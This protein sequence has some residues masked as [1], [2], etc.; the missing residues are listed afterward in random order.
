[1]RIMGKLLN[2]GLAVLPTV[3]HA[4]VS[5]TDDITELLKLQGSQTPLVMRAA[6]SAVTLQHEESDIPNKMQLHD[7]VG[8]QASAK[9]TA[10][11]LAT[12]ALR[13]QQPLPVASL[14]VGEALTYQFLAGNTVGD[15]VVTPQDQQAKT[16]ALTFLRFAQANGLDAAE[17]FL[18]KLN[19]G[20]R[21]SIAQPDGA[22]GTMTARAAVEAFQSNG[23]GFDLKYASKTLSVRGPVRVVA[24]VGNKASVTLTGIERGDSDKQRLSDEIS[25]DVDDPTTVATLSPKQVVSVTGTYN[26]QLSHGVGRIVLTLCRVEGH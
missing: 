18:A 1:M 6:C 8:A 19:N 14:H 26:K 10:A 5:S 9:V 24:A 20:G 11:H 21:Q 7:F 22:A 2:A 3:L 16:N 25:C 23:V 15:G 17:P 12:C 4:Q 13:T